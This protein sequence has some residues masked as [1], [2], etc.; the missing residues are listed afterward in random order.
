MR[1]TTLILSELRQEIQKWELATPGSRE[2]NEAAEAAT[3]LMAELDI[4]LCDGADLPDPWRRA[5][6]AKE[7]QVHAS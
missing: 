5:S 6:A 3:R 4:A 1:S 7:E 2:E